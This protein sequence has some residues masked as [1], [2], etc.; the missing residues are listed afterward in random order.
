[1]VDLPTPPLQEETAIICRTLDKENGCGLMENYFKLAANAWGISSGKSM[2]TTPLSRSICILAS[3]VESPEEMMAPAWPMRLPA[4][5]VRP[6]M[7]ETMGLVT[8]FLMK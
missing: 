2:T 6:A 7:K 8:C 1:M 3:A 5:A 4:G